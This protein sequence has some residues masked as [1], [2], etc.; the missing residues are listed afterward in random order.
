MNELFLA[1]VLVC[2]THEVYVGTKSEM[3]VPDIQIRG[4][5]LNAWYATFKNGAQCTLT[6]SS[7]GVWS[8]QFKD[9]DGTTLSAKATEAPKG[10]S[11]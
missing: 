9:T 3:A 10:K 11:R 6:Q 8:V 1:I 2:Q 7:N 5:T 4:E